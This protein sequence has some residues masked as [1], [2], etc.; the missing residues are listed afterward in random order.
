MGTAWGQ[1]GDSMG[2]PRGQYEDTIGTPWGQ[3][4]DT[5]G[6]PWRHHGHS[7][8]IPWGQYGDTKDTVW[9]HSGDSMGTMRAPW[10]QY[11]DSL[12][13]HLQDLLD[14]AVARGHEV[15]C[16]LGHPD[17]LQPLG[18]GAEGDA[19]RATGA[20]QADGHPEWGGTRG[21]GGVRNGAGIGGCK[22]GAEMGGCK[23]RCDHGRMQKNEAEMQRCKK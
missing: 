9:E 8:R 4:E 16:V 3:Y 10:G 1:Y 11:G 7:R 14:G 13:G 22:N 5:V 18:D 19:L 23:N 15:L 12:G 20:G 6:T 21:G 2:T 17:G